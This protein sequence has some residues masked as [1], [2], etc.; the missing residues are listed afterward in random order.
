MGA[1]HTLIRAGRAYW[2]FNERVW[3][4]IRRFDRPVKAVAVGISIALW[5]IGMSTG[6]AVMEWAPAVLSGIWLASV[7]IVDAL[8]STRRG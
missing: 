2:R 6:N 1:M 4:Y 3:L 8:D 7:L 5:I